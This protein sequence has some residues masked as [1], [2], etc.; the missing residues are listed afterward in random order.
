VTTILRSLPYFDEKSV[1][2]VRNQAKAV[3][4]QQIVVW[5]S[6]AESE[7]EELQRG[8]PR[9]PAILDTGFSHN[10]GIRE[11]LLRQWAGI[12]PAYFPRMGDIRVNNVTVP[13]YDADVWL[14]RNQPGQRDELAEG[15]PFRLALNEG[16]VVYP[17]DTPNAPRLPVLGL[18][19]LKWT[20][21]QLSI[22][23]DRLRV[24]LRTRRRFWP[25]G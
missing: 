7:Q 3:K 14:Y 5:V 10:F 12:Q 22:D 13:R 17:A 23:T 24:G 11:E 9:F 8:T 19:G 2:V 1:V 6:V 4:R 16:I 15:P 21:P 18:R 25:F 20:G